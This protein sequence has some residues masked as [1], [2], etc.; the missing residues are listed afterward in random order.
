MG[1]G[2]PCLDFVYRRLGN[3]EGRRDL[4]MSFTS[5]KPPSDHHH[6][7]LSKLGS[8]VAFT[9]RTAFLGVPV[10]HVSSMRIK[11]QVF[12]VAAGGVVAAVA[13]A[14]TFGDWS[15]LQ[16]VGETVSTDHLPGTI[17]H[18]VTVIIPVTYPLNTAGDRVL[19]SQLG[20][21]PF[22]RRPLVAPGSVGISTFTEPFVVPPTQRLRVMI[23]RTSFN[24]A[25]RFH[26][27]EPRH[28]SDLS[29][30]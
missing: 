19:G 22:F 7:I 30:E 29:C 12:L 26:K 13:N 11:I 1:P 2:P 9:F 28:A 3:P 5:G 6:I 15:V 20:F 16:F 21:E 25:L 14:Q 10:R 18:P 27:K 17:D 4:A 24:L 8:A 23:P